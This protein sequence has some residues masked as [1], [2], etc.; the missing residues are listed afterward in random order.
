MARLATAIGLTLF[1][2]NPWF[3]ALRPGTKN[4]NCIFVRTDS[5]GGDGLDCDA[6][7]AAASIITG[8]AAWIRL[9]ISGLCALLLLV[10]S[11]S[12]GQQRGHR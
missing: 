10:V 4:P 6:H 8:S 7:S 12:D 2:V 11:V 5:M 3:T 9:W 1:G